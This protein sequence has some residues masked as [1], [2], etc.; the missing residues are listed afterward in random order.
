MKDRLNFHLHGGT[1]GV[2]RPAPATA[3]LS[4]A[5]V[6]PSNDGEVEP[7]SYDEATVGH[8]KYLM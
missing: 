8:R 1:G 2:A 5:D 7:P 6:I 4:L 3:S